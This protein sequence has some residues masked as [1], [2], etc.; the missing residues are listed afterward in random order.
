VLE[1][2]DRVARLDQEHVTGGGEQH[3]SRRAREEL[4]AE[5]LLEGAHV[6]AERGLRQMQPVGRRADAALFGDGDEV[7][8]M[9]ELDHGCLDRPD[10][11]PDVPKG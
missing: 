5:A 3:P 4:D 8:E 7:D 10:E 6:P 1:A 11:P 9:L 2:G